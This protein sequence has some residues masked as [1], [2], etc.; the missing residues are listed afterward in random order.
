LYPSPNITKVKKA[1]RIRWEGHVT[2]MREM[3]KAYSILDGKPEEKRN[4]R[5]SRRR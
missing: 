1:R 4:F 2:R 3:G 5:R